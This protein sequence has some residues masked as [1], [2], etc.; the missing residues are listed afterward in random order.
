MFKQ[1]ANVVNINLNSKPKH[2][3]FSSHIGRYIY[4]H[5]LSKNLEKK[6]HKKHP[7]FQRYISDALQKMIFS[8]RVSVLFYNINNI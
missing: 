4:L 8:L 6:Q 2:Y 1:S 5:L 3:D 7:F